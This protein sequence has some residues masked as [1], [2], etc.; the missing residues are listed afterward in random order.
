MDT[1]QFSQ[2]TLDDIEKAARILA[3]GGL[4][5]VPTETVYGLAAD[6]DNPQAVRSTFAAKGRPANHPLIVHVTGFDALSSWVSEIPACTR[7]LT[8]A[9]WPGPLTLVFKRSARVNDAV[10]GGQDTVAVRCPSHPVMRA[11]L[12]RFEGDT[13]KAVTAPSANTF[14]QIS[15]T[16]AQH[17]AEDLGVKPAGKLDMIL[18]GGECEVGVEST[19]LN[20]T[21][22]KP[23]ILRFG[24]VTAKM[25]SE[26]LGFEVKEAGAD[27]PRV[28]GRL[29]SHYAPHT[30]LV[31]APAEKLGEYDPARCA[32]LFCGESALSRRIA[33]AGAASITA[34]AD[35]AGYA[36]ALYAAMHTLD[37][38]GAE[39]IV[40]EAPPA[41]PAWAAVNDRL[42]RAAADK[43][44]IG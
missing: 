37:A 30:K 19:I 25:L 40:V 32:F 36:H 29:K 38:S 33:A 6:A 7:A 27:A 9:F 34:P 16:T 23:E 2:K 13:H 42:G 10:T 12:Q 20:L 26:V 14:G 28:S 17:V 22:E 15:P 21:S 3:A 39:R 11:L 41:D 31:I 43:N 5:A 8:D 24:A 35:P 1:P 44:E 18:D 4:V